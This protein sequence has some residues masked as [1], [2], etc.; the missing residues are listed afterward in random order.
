MVDKQSFVGKGVKTIGL[1]DTI[2]KI[3]HEQ[4]DSWSDTRGVARNFYILKHK[5]VLRFVA[6][7]VVGFRLPSRRVWGHAPTGVLDLFNSIW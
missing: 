1:K 3:Y 4:P 2:L 7:Y 6:T 5:I